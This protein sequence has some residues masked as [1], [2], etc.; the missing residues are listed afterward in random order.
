MAKGARGTTAILEPASILSLVRTSRSHGKL[1]PTSRG[2]EGTED[3]KS[4]PAV[5][6]LYHRGPLPSN[7]RSRCCLSFIPSTSPPVLISTVRI[8]HE[9]LSHDAVGASGGHGCSHQRAAPGLA[10]HRQAHQGQ[11]QALLWRRYRPGPPD[12]LGRQERRHHREELWPGLAREQHEVAEPQQPKGLVQLGPGR[13]PRQL[14]DGAQHLDPR[15]HARLALA[16][17]R[18]GQQHQGQGDAHVGHAGAYQ[19]RHGAVEGQDQGMGEFLF[20][21]SFEPSPH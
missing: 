12:P 6:Y 21:P 18:L 17:R 16:A 8:H 10:E 11:G 20:A 2:G 4:P 13:L 1:Q 15:P 7:Y 14:G 3:D 5:S 19:D 9:G